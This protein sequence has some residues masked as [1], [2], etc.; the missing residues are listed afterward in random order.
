MEKVPSTEPEG[1][2]TVSAEKSLPFV[3][4]IV[5]C[6][7]EERYIRGCLDSLIANDYPKDRLEILIVE[8]MSD[9]STPTIVE[10]YAASYSFIRVIANPRRI[11]PTALNLG[12]QQSRGDVIMIAD[13]HS[14]Y[15]VDY[16]SSNVKYL[17]DSGADNVGGVGRILPARQTKIAQTISLVLSHPFG[18]GNAYVKTGSSKPRWTDAVAFGC[19]R[20]EIFQRI[21]MF[22]EELVRSSDL[23]FNNRIRRAGGKIL[24]VFLA[25]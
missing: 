24:L 19:Y 18:S 3:T 20:R 23:D 9:D 4:V 8:G 16:I 13:A 22:R 14:F 7:N 15:P 6:R 11:K 21:G 17:L 5:P 2:E 12:V 1:G 25:S 10:E